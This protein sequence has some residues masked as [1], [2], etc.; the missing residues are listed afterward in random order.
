MQ[1]INCSTLS[2]AP[3]ARPRAIALPFSDARTCLAVFGA[4]DAAT[5]RELALGATS[6]GFR[7]TG[8]DYPP[9]YRDNDRLVR[10]DPDL[11]RRLFDRLKAALPQ[12]I[13]DSDGVRWRLVG[14]NE[15]FRFCRYS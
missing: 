15:R 8:A 9:S 14:L 2:I 10:D 1:P 5:C 6:E 4:L 3:K 11:A 12:T 7:P 13:V